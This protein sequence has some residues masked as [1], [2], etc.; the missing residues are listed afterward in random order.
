MNGKVKISVITYVKNG[1][2]YIKQ[3]LRS[4]AEQTL[5]EIEILVVDA[6][7]T[8]GT[9]EYLVEQ[10][11]LDKRMTVI[12]CQPSV[13]QQFNK[14]LSVASGEYIAICEADDYICPDAYEK[15][16]E[17]AENTEC[18]VIRANYNQFFGHAGL[19][20]KFLT[21]ACSDSTLYNQKIELTDDFFL[22]EG[23]HGFWSGLYRKEFLLSNNIRMSETPGASYQDIGF[24]FQCQCLA[25]TVYFCNDTFYQYRLDNP[26]ASMNVRNRV[27]KIINEFECLEQELKRKGIWSKYQDN[28]FEWEFIA[29][30]K[31]YI[32]LESDNKDKI[33]KE[34]LLA[35]FNQRNRN[36]I[37]DDADWNDHMREYFL[38]QND[39][40]DRL[41]CFLEKIRDD[42]R[43][44]IVWGAGLMGQVTTSVLDIYE[45]DYVV[46]DNNSEV[47]GTKLNGHTV[48]SPKEAV[49]KFHNAVYFVANV[50]HS[51]EIRDQ[52]LKLGI[53][54]E[55]IFICNND[56]ILLR[57]ILA[58]S[59]K[60]FKL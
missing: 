31:A 39:E 16:Y 40:I 56:E 11:S 35:L 25:H 42:E 59:N 57:K 26:F 19:E 34:I 36:G 6:K 22:R 21:H 47:Q 5:K 54:K 60:N 52:M 14:A 55:N 17:I 51:G 12:T 49:Q 46:V 58:L 33:L 28:Y 3:C 48:L 18:D 10:A 7:S 27:T 8:D 9:Y 50:N 13:G 15:L 45:K 2:P 53:K 29:L 43:K 24:S 23:I 1:F 44:I 32:S 4:I 41:L 37:V 38:D 30:K 20:T